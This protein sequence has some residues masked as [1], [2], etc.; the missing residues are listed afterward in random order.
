MV[1]IGEKNF[2]FLKT[3]VSGSKL[4]LTNRAEMD[5][6]THKNDSLCSCHFIVGLLF[7]RINESHKWMA[8]NFQDDFLTAPKAGKWITHPS[9]I[10]IF[11]CDFFFP[12]PFPSIEHK[13]CHV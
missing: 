2:H 13:L 10:S 11:V 7:H 1:K 4:V 6:F 3:H 9:E 5:R 12:V 8:Q